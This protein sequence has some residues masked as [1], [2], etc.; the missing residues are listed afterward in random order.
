MGKRFLKSMV[1][2]QRGITGLETAIILIAFVVVA[3]VFAYTVLSAGIFSSEK[4]RETIESG[5][6]NTTSAIALSGKVI[7]KDTNGDRNVDQLIFTLA[8]VVGQE[9][10]VDLSHTT[11]TDNDGLLSDESNKNHTMVI[12]Y[13]D[14]DQTVADIAWTK[15]ALGKNDGDDILEA[16]EKFQITV[17]LTTALSSSYPL[18]AYDT[19]TI[20]VKPPKG[21]AVTFSKTIPPVTSGV[22]V[23][24]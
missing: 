23:L 7:A 20:E 24:N 11:D 14:R 17:Y 19:F 8:S 4:G 21:G 22:M 18:N 9:S 6:G 5:I 16:G 13:F 12:T 2:A 3:S 10:S 15:T 1:R